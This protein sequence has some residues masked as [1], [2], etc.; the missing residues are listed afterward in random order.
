MK[1][2]II[3][4]TILLTGVSSN[5]VAQSDAMDNFTVRVDGLGCPFCAYGLEKKFKELKG[6]E[7]VE[8]EMET[9]VMTFAYPAA[10]A[11]AMARVEQQVEK[12]GYTPVSVQV[13]RADGR[14]ETTE[15]AQSANT[16]PMGNVES[17]SFYVAGN[18]DMCKSR[19]ERAVTSVEGVQRATWDKKT[20]QLTVESAAEVSDTALH[21]AVARVGHDTKQAKA[22]NAT[23]NDL[24]GCCH[25]KRLK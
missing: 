7:E 13:A 8:I 1:Y 22:D 16:T 12:A 19:I 6:I 18:C 5:L 14:T 15:D 2:I 23:Y 10:K 20:K 4:F 24:P 9:G 11:L 3:A 17:T 21:K 25:Y